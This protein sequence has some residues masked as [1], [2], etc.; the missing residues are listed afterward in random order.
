MKL[1]ISAYA[2]LEVA[3]RLDFVYFGGGTPSVLSRECLRGLIAE[4][5]IQF[6][7][8]RERAPLPDL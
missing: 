6:E 2:D 5:R 8:A 7:L 1:E 4:L 3:R